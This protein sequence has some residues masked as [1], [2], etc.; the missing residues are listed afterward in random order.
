V[1]LLRTWLSASPWIVVPWILAPAF[2]ERRQ[3][4]YVCTDCWTRVTDREIGV[5]STQ[6]RTGATLAIRHGIIAASAA[7]AFAPLWH[8]REGGGCP[9]RP[10]P[11]FRCDFEPDG[12]Q[13]VWGGT[14]W[15]TC[16]DGGLVR[17]A[18]LSLAL[19]EDPSFAEF[20]T[21]RIS[22]GR[23]KQEQVWQ[24]LPV[25]WR[26]YRTSGLGHMWMGAFPS[27]DEER[28]L[29]QLATTLVAEHRGVDPRSLDLWHGIDPWN[30]ALR[31]R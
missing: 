9:P 25:S 15:S 29:M 7:G 4:K 8:G 28:R 1:S 19:R 12:S 17:E 11:L 3:S 13:G 31:E 20:L 14:M 24:V 16:H 21:E 26:S 23:I 2:T 30:A 22:D 6:R 27:S 5:R 10:M 18:G